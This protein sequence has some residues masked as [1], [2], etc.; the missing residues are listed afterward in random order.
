MPRPPMILF[1]PI[2]LLACSNDT[3]APADNAAFAVNESQ[4]APVD[5]PPFV[6]HPVAEFD[7]PWAMAF[8]PDGRLLVTEKAGALK[9]YSPSSSAVTDVAGVPDVVHRGQGGF[10]DIVPDP[11]FGEER[12]LYL[13]WVEAGDGGSSGAVVG[14]ARLVEN[15]GQARLDGL[16]IIWRQQPKVTG[17]G[18]F[19][20]RIAFSPDGQYLFISSGERQK[21]TPAQDMSTNLGK[22]VRLRPD[23]SVPDDNPFAQKGGVT[24][25]IW[26]LG[27][28]NILGMAF[29]A[30]GRLWAHEMG[31]RG[32][33]ELNLIKKGENYGYPIVSNGDHYD[34]R[35][36]PDHDTQPEFQAP[37]LSWT[38]VISPAG[39]VIYSG[40]LFPRW[41]GSMLLG[42]LSGQALVRVALN[43]ENARK[44]D[45][46]NM[47]QRIREVEQ[48]PDGALWLLEDG[49]SARLLK[50]T[51]R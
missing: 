2:A 17:S 50:L 21:F 43:G 33:D 30:D 26:S 31:P 15:D 23:G 49:P 39:A 16:Q 14:R 22:I 20:H 9:L 18:H 25:Q 5:R 29:D 28:R 24:A 40:N 38:P 10:G 44:A 8:L 27:H 36:I 4:I 6:V 12:F 48:G 51:P 47:D 11:A 7:E 13:S 42:A 37:K 34:G 1:A 46:W 41:K 3:G 19:A 45:R 32:G 35:P